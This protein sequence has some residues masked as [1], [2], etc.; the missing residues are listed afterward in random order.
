[1]LEK[2]AYFPGVDPNGN[3]LVE[4]ITFGKGLTK[5]AS[6]T[7]TQLHPQISTYLGA[8]KESEEKLYVLV[9]ALGSWEYWGQNI[10]GDIFKDAVLRNEDPR[11]GY[12]TFLN[13]GIYRHHVNK[14]PRKSMGEV[15]VAI[16]NPRMHRVELVLCIDRARARALGHQ[17]LIDELDCGGNP[18]VSMGMKTPH[19]ICSVCGNHSKTQADYCECIRMRKGTILPDGRMIGMINPVFKAFDISFVLIGA[20]KASFAI[21]AIG[22]KSSKAKAAVPCHLWTPGIEKVAGAYGSMLKLLRLHAN[23]DPRQTGESKGPSRDVPLLADKRVKGILEKLS[24]MKLADLTKQ[25]PIM[26]VLDREEPSIPNGVLDHLGTRPL[27]PTFATLGSLGMILK[28]RE[29][30]RIVLTRLGRPGLSDFMDRMGQTFPPCACARPDRSVRFGRGDLDRDLLA[31]MLPM[32]PHR[33]MFAPLL[34]RR[35]ATTRG[36]SVAPDVK[37][38]VAED[39]EL[40]QRLSAGYAG[41]LGS[42]IEKIAELANKVALQDPAVVATLYPDALESVLLGNERTKQAGAAE[43]ALMFGVLPA[44][45]LLA[46]ATKD[47]NEPVVRNFVKKHPVITASM[48]IGLLRAAT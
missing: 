30:Q 4:A 10:N 38:K 45:Y 46:K 19:D 11:N 29:Y 13:A 18:A 20:D 22:G 24:G 21:F 39:S 14:D 48:L 8:L 40:M 17:D 34:E 35:L 1:M 2:R 31:T 9:N 44:M 41:Y 23:N 12:K 6:V 27:A 3:P 33:S 28:P 25:V 37:T 7:T 26:K 43:K 16:W 36:L 47:D 15:V 42:T 5:T 32:M